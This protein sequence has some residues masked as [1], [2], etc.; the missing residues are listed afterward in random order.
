MKF[1]KYAIQLVIAG[2]LSVL[3]AVYRMGALP[4]NAAGRIMAFSDAFFIVGI[5]YFCISALVWVSTTGFFDM[6]SYA[7]RKGAHALIPGQIHDNVGG[8]YEYK[9]EKQE[10]RG[11]KARVSGLFVGLLMLV[12]AIILTAVW[13]CI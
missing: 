1:K 8:F 2:V 6:L 12:I 3:L 10:K 13:Y 4:K 11:G 5:L 7:F 9:M